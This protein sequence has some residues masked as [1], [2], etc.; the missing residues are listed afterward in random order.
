MFSFLDME[1]IKFGEK[2]FLSYQ[3]NSLEAIDTVEVEMMKN[4]ELDGILPFSDTQNN[5]AITL[6]YDITKRIT[7]RQFL[8]G[9][10]RW[11]DLSKVLGDIAKILADSERY[12]M[13]PEHFILSQEQIYVD[14]QTRTPQLLFIPLENETASQITW[15][16]FMLNVLNDITYDSRDCDG[17]MTT[18]RTLI[19]DDNISLGELQKKIPLIQEEPTKGNMFASIDKNE[20]NMDMLGGFIPDPVV[21]N[22]VKSKPKF[23]MPDDVIEDYMTPPKEKKSKGKKRLFRKKNEPVSLGFDIP[24]QEN[25]VMFPKSSEKIVEN[26]QD[27]SQVQDFDATE[28]IE[29]EV[30]VFRPMIVEKSTGKRIAI[31]KP[32]FRIGREPGVV[33]HLVTNQ[34]VGRLHASIVLDNIGKKAFIR[35]ANSKNGTYV[36]GKRIQSNINV[37]LEDGVSFRLGK[38]EFLYK[39]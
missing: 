32:E 21:E 34:T 36:D 22:K 1:T 13:N 19:N 11:E 17:N 14:V 27:I 10:V 9:L 24:G 20:D 3:V 2:D 6:M 38:E 37:R 16:Q 25:S 30:S 5:D 33:E 29:E 4:N 26:Q 35:D 31:D 12:M 39:E 8:G 15:R 28:L 18:L 23:N 7:M